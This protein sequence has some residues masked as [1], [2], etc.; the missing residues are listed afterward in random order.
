MS[1]PARLLALPEVQRRVPLHRAT[2]WRLAAR[3]AFPPPL[4]VGSRRFWIEAEIDE[5][6]A[7]RITE[8]DRRVA[9]VVAV[10]RVGSR[11]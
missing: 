3:G 7:S 2:I 8:R 1:G 5:W 11:P 4:V 6:L 9:A 10:R